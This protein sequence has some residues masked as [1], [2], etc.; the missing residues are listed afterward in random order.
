MSQNNQTNNNQT[1]VTANQTPANKAAKAT[2]AKPMAKKATPA[3]QKTGRS[4][5]IRTQVGFT[6]TCIDSDTFSDAQLAE[7]LGLGKNE[8]IAIDVA[9]A[10]RALYEM[11]K[12]HAPI[13]CRRS[14]NKGNL[15]IQFPM[16]LDGYPL[17]KLHIT[18]GAPASVSLSGKLSDE[19]KREQ[20]LSQ[21]KLS[22]K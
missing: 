14:N 17:V 8:V 15:T 9:A 18:E 7:G 12:D 4:A 3:P 10:A 1:P 16:K 6:V 5:S 11:L 19:Q 22:V 13:P 21:L 20:L 2:F